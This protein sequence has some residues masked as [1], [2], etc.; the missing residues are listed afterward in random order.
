MDNPFLHSGGRQLRAGTGDQRDFFTSWVM[1]GFSGRRCCSGQPSLCIIIPAEALKLEVAV[2][3]TSPTHLSLKTGLS[4][5]S[6][7]F[8]AISLSP[9][10]SSRCISLTED[11]AEGGSVSQ[12][13]GIFSLAPCSFALQ[14][15]LSLHLYL[16]LLL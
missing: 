10:V 1:Q 4:L 14:S 12:S 11:T 5:A 16:P 7:W 8:S 9:V 2:T 6:P 3:Q 15:Q 13:G